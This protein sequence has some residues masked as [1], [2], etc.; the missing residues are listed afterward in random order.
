MKITIELPSKHKPNKYGVER[1]LNHIAH[2]IGHMPIDRPAP[3]LTGV[4]NVEGIEV[5]Y[6]I[7]D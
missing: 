3:G 6:S 4:H 5:K 7:T 1:V 2:H